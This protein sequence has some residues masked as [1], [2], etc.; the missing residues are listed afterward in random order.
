MPKTDVRQ[1][2]AHISKDDRDIPLLIY[3]GAKE[4]FFYELR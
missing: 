2:A 4:L 3:K 1:Q